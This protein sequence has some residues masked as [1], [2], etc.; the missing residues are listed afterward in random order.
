[1]SL[2]EKEKEKEKE[3]ILKLFITLFRSITISCGTGNI[4][5]ECGEY[6]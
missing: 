5:Y 6:P 2:E 4:Q 3:K 1:M